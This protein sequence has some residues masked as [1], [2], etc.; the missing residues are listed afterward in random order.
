M[1]D[2]CGV[3]GGRK[4][5]ARHEIQKQSSEILSNILNIGKN[6]T[7]L[8]IIAFR[9]E[10][11]PT[12][13]KSEILS[14]IIKYSTVSDEIKTLVAQ[15]NANYEYWDTVKYKKTP[16]GVSSKELWTY[17]VAERLKTDILV[18]PKH[19]IHFALTNK[20]QQLCHY[21][22]MN[23]GGSWE[24]SSIIPNEHRERYLVSSLM[25]EAISSSQMEGASTTRKIAK[26]MLRQKKK[27]QDRSQQM[28][29]NNYQTIRFIVEHKETPLSSSLLLKV[30]QLMTQGTLDN[31]DDCGRYRQTDDI[32]VGNEITGEI[33][34]MPPS[35]D[36]ISSFI[37]DLCTFFNNEDQT[38]FTHPIIKGIIIH[39]LTAYIHPFVDGNGRTSRALFY[40]YM[41]K[42]GY[43]LTEYLS[44]SR[45]IYHSKAKYEKA[46]LYA[47]NDGNDIGYFI[48]YNLKVLQQAFDELQNYLKRKIQEQKSATLFLQL[49][50]VNERQAEII[51]MFYDNPNEMLTVKVLQ[52]HFMVTPTTVKSDLTGLLDKEIIKEIPLNK[53]KKGYIKGPLFDEI[54]KG[55][56]L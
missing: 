10:K 47:E 16:N 52:S 13:N 1:C 51:K 44:I 50:D 48:S 32:V 33:V 55:I 24:S 36:E 40:W 20:M 23:F 3:R 7:F 11:H 46:F 12:I 26:E 27:P 28:I 4:H 19:N 31:K 5:S 39:F 56:S 41:L 6:F 29:Y 42:Q 38:Q 30:H 49:K 8:R 9:M 21:F 25:E 15:V 22:D 43:W 17:V 14:S 35:K 34:H 18:W 54:T 45:V 37:S 2:D 53:V